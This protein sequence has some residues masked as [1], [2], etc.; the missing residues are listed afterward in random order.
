MDRM[1]NLY[2]A[3]Q[4]EKNN[5]KV[6]SVQYSLI[7]QRAKLSLKILGLLQA[8]LLITKYYVV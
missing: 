4:P 6:L 3:L 2:G 5:V 1:S 7:C 8:V